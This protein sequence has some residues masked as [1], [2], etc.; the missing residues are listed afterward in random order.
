[1]F[2]PATKAAVQ[3]FQ[4]ARRLISDGICGPLTWAKLLA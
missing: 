4:L 2:G 1:V 3:A